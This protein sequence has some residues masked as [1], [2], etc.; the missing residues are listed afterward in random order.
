MSTLYTLI[1]Y[2]MH[3]DQ[4]LNCDLKKTQEHQQLVRSKLYIPTNKSLT[5]ISQVNNNLFLLFLFYLA[6]W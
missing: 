2:A 5:T 6:K 4:I 3:K 1:H